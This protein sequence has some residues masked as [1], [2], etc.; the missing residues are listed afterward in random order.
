MLPHW[1]DQQMT[2]NQDINTN[3]V[4]IGTD[5]EYIAWDTINVTNMSGMFM[6]NIN[7]NQNIEWNTSN[8]TNMSYMFLRA[9]NFNQDI[10]VKDKIIKDGYL[11]K[12]GDYIWNNSQK[13]YDEV[14]S[15]ETIKSQDNSDDISEDIKSYMKRVEEVELKAVTAERAVLTQKQRVEA[16]EKAVRIG[17]ATG[18]SKQLKDYQSTTLR[19]EYVAYDSLLAKS[20]RAREEADSLAEGLLKL[21]RIGDNLREGID[22]VFRKEIVTATTTQNEY[23]VYTPITKKQLE[24]ESTTGLVYP[25]IYVAW[26]TSKVTNMESMFDNASNFNPV[27]NDKG[28][29]MV[30]VDNVTN[31][32]NMFRGASSFNNIDISIWPI[33]IEL[34]A[35]GL[36][37]MFTSPTGFDGDNDIWIQKCRI[38]TT[39]KSKLNM[40]E[41]EIIY[42]QNDADEDKTLERTGAD[43]GNNP[44][45]PFEW[46]TGVQTSFGYEKTI[47]NRYHDSWNNACDVVK[48]INSHIFT[49]TAWSTVPERPSNN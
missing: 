30:N 15:S 3:T 38:M 48:F 5:E 26:N 10:L 21:P 24:S 1:S 2:F 45:E 32:K 11:L 23:D 41:N 20:V 9:I 6:N 7:F 14:L 25:K 22:N 13:K 18:V 12:K 47:H 36:Y 8:V 27:S 31:M 46:E 16:A 40:L 28:S 29:Y 49:Q 39:L 44:L 19:N 17:I 33:N 34:G 43:N 4:N 35:D 37:G 42:I